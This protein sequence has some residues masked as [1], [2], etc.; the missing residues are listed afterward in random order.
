[1]SADRERVDLNAVRRHLAASSDKVTWQSL[2]D[3]VDD[4]DLQALM[5]REFPPGVEEM[6]NPLTRRRFL[7]LA[8][9]S[10]A[11]G[12]LSACGK[13]AAH[14]LPYVEQ[15]EDVVPGN[16]LY[17]ATAH[18]LGGYAQ[19]IL[20]ESHTGRPTKIEG[21]PDHPASLG[22]TDAFAQASVLSLYDPDRSQS[23]M[24]EAEQSSW[25]AFE[26]VLA[27]ALA[28]QR[29]G[30]GAG[31]R[32]LTPTITSPTLI[33]QLERLLDAYPNARWHQ[34]EPV[35]WDNA[36]AG[37]ALAFGRPV[38]PVYDFSAADVVLALDAD[39]LTV[40]P[41]RVRYMHDFSRRRRVGDEDLSM[42][43][44]YAATPTLTLTSSMADHAWSLAPQA[45]EHFARAVARQV[46][47]DVEP[48]G[49][50][51]AHVAAVVE[52]LAR[53]L[54]AHAG[55][56]LVLAGIGQPPAVHALCHALNE[57]MDN[58]GETVQYI[59]PVQAQDGAAGKQTE[60]LRALVDEMAAG[61]VDLLLILGGNPAYTAPADL[62]FAAA[63]RN[64]PMSVHLSDYRDE[65]S[66]QCTWHL[67]Q[68][69]FLETWSD[70]RAFDGTATIMQ[71]LIEPLYDNRSAHEVLNLVL[72][73]EPADSHAIVKRTWQ[74][75]L[76]RSDFEI[77]WQHALQVGVVP[78]TAFA[79]VDVR[80]QAD[81]ALPEA[82]EIPD[83]EL[84]AIFAP[85][86]TV[87]DGAYS[88]NAWLQELPKP[89]TR[90]T[91]DNAA[92]I[93]PA[94]ATRLGLATEDMVR[95]R[96]GEHETL[97]PVWV[98]P[99]QAENCVTLHLGYGRLSAGL[100]G[101][102]AGFNAYRLRTETG[103]WSA[104][105]LTLE[106]T[107][108]TAVL[109]TTQAHYSTD[110]RN[111]VRAATLATF[112][113]NPSFAQVHPEEP[114]TLYPDYEYDDHAWGM[115]INLQTCTGCQACVIACQAENNV[116]VVGK[117][118]V[119]EGREMHWL[120]I[121]EYFEADDLDRMPR[122][123]HQPVPCMHCEHA[124]C[125]PVCP[126]KATTHSSEGLNE[127]TY[128]RCVGTRYCANN[129]P[130]QV[131]HF[132]FFD[133]AAEGDLIELVRNPN[134]SVRWRGVMEKCTYCVQ[135]INEARTS[136][137]QEGRAIRDGEIR[138]ACQQACPADAIIFGDIN[139][140]D[141]AVTRRKDDP[142]DYGLLAELGTR[143]RTT[144]LAKVWNPNPEIG[145]A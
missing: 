104:A 82:A 72:E 130:Y 78:D 77:V 86:P 32:I 47:L 76:A 119:R 21:N 39:F 117:E 81:F 61:T 23:V 70:A 131:R 71:P 46:G 50:V 24:V 139:D 7:Q 142:R 122:T 19:G 45:I 11:L 58:V 62:D 25:A 99:G 110:P 59:E 22:A 14:I 116:P 44:L 108:E 129:C 53:D 52:P 27:D 1:M 125:E 6:N 91:W 83:S 35:N 66:I 112:E 38:E 140:P 109:A 135:R 101:D 103:T 88:N 95:L 75:R 127:M 18:V 36:Y 133:Y 111:A 106:K 30:A 141:A 41:G 137:R 33:E 87:W 64:V 60:S 28:R 145:G 43:R 8:A 13:P 93:S 63:L 97:A 92:L 107:G 5:R 48:S 51:P 12:G 55:R 67:P 98:M 124:P 134:V 143:P 84:V 29:D 74:A 102:R 114:P 68:S 123:Y 3:V 94:L 113:E 4:A 126:V 138:T 85:D 128:N 17:F 89:F 80:V 120:R 2:A 31:L 79:P 54:Q 118:G 9:A 57:M 16:P 105:G 132:N 20:A 115:S 42:S 69:H 40:H 90:L 144:Y 26:A 10:L 34:Y 73:D 100:V 96:L 65:T 136:A 56:S 37:A 49:D 121:D 15:P